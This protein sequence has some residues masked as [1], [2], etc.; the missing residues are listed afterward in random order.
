MRVRPVFRAGAA[1]SMLSSEGL[2]RAAAAADIDRGAR[3]A[4]AREIIRWRLPRNN[5]P[6]T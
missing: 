3:R 6:R 4:A 1:R 2:A 5:S